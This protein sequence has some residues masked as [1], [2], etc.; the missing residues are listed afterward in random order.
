MGRSDVDGTAVDT[1]TLERPRVSR[2]GTLQVAFAE[3]EHPSSLLDCADQSKARVAQCVG[4]IAFVI[5]GQQEPA[6]LQVAGAGPRHVGCI[7][8]E[9]EIE[10]RVGQREGSG[11][12][13]PQEAQARGR[14]DVPPALHELAD[15]QNVREEATGQI[16]PINVDNVLKPERGRDV[17]EAA[18]VQDRLKREPL[19]EEAELTRDE[20]EML[21]TN[22]PV[23]LTRS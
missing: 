14:T 4:R 3:C 16:V 15:P 12:V 13:R 9:D 1:T 19:V 7:H 23:V 22:S 21:L 10:A 5:V 11:V 8:C 20:V 18:G 17:Q 6:R 2:R